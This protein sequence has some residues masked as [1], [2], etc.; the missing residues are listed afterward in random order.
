[1]KRTKRVLTATHKAVFFDAG[2]TLLR[3]Y[4]SVGEIYSDFAKKHGK[5]VP[6]DEVNRVFYELWHRRNGLAALKTGTGEKIEKTWWRDLVRDVFE[7]FGGIDNFDKFFDDLYHSF[8]SKDTWKVFEE[9]ERVLRTLKERGYYLAIISNWDSRLLQICRSLNLEKYFDAIHASA[10]VGYAKPDPRIF[11][12]AL[13]H[14]GVLAEEA[15]HV[16]DSIEDDYFGAKA[17]GIKALFLDRTGEQNHSEIH[18]IQ[19]LADIL[20]EDLT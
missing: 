2:G 14:A 3:P 5:K 17:L 11:Q 19:S 10:L 16:G 13:D 20:G 15:I 12:N 6:S 7:R 18:A 1:L 4:P 8:A 9:T